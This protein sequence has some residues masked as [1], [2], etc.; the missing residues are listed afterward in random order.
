MEEKRIR[1]IEDNYLMLK[2][3][4]E[5]IL[6]ELKDIKRCSISQ[7]E[8]NLANEKLVER[9]FTKVEKKF[10]RKEKV[11]SI[12]KSLKNIVGAIFAVSISVVIYLV[13][14]IITMI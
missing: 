2:K 11:E 5:Q 1:K 9:V 13:Q 14:K 6:K 3:N 7:D 12:E 4:Q 8:M 10:A